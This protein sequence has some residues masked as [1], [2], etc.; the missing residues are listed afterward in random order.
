MLLLLSTIPASVLPPTADALAHFFESFWSAWGSRALSLAGGGG[1][2]AEGEFVKALLEC[3]LRE[4]AAV[5]KEADGAQLGAELVSEWVGRTW[6][7]LVG[8]DEGERKVR[9]AERDVVIREL[10]EALERLASRGSG[11]SASLSRILDKH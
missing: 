11:P 8:Q 6:Q 7:A 9:K 5:A 10:R 1:A 4:Q 3:V 2:G